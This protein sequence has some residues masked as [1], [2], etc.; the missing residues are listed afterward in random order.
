MYHNPQPF[1]KKEINLP[2]STFFNLPAPKREK[3]LR[4]AVAEFARKPFADASINRIIQDAEIPRGSFYQYFTDKSDLFRF[5]LTY[6]SQQMGFLSWTIWMP[7][8]GTCWPS[9]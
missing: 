8:A 1:R 4:A 3:L 6:F 2:T 7:A 5:I 9:R